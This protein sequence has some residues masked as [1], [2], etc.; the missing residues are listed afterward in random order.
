MSKRLIKSFIH[1][2]RPIFYKL[3]I[4]R[5]YYK[6]VGRN[7]IGIK[8]NKLLTNQSF[9]DK[10]TKILPTDDNISSISEIEKK[11]IIES[12][13]K[14]LSGNYNIL[15]SGDVIMNPIDWHSD[16]K[17]SFTWKKG[18]YYMD[19]IQVQLENDADVKVPRELSRSHHLLHVALA[20]NL[21]K[22]EEF[23]DFLRLQIINWIEENP[24]MYSINWGCAMDVSIRAVNW[25]WCL[26]LLSDYD[27][28]KHDKDLRFIKV[29][30][31]QHGWFIFRNLEGSI[32]NYTNNH[33]LSNLTGLIFLGQ[34]FNS[35]SDG[36]K[37]LNYGELSFYREIRIQILPSGIT[38]ERS[39]HYNRLVLELILWPL[40]SLKCS[41]NKIPQDIWSR[42][43]NMFEFIMHTSRPD[44]SCPIIGDQDNGRLLPFGTEEL[45]DFQY[46]L[47]IGSLLFKRAEFKNVD[48][49]YNIYSALLGSKYNLNMYEEID[50]FKGEIKSIGFNDVGLYVMRTNKNYLIFNGS[51]RGLYSD[52]KSLN[53][54]SH[55]DL[56]SF[57]L[58]IRDK[59]F[60]IDPGTYVYTSNKLERNLFR[61]TRKHNTVVVDGQNQ[62]KLS[63]N[64]LFQM[65]RDSTSTIKEWTT[66]NQQDLISA[67]HNGY[68]SLDEPVKHLRSITFEKLSENWLI[69]DQLLGDGI[70]DFEV[71]FHFNE[72]INI[73]IIDE[74]TIVT[75][76]KGSNLEL[77]F[78][79]N[80]DFKIVKEISYISKSYGTK[81]KSESVIIK[82]NSSCPFILET[83]IQII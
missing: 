54:H 6:F 56:F 12:A 48:Q 18:K 19:Y 76:S 38:Y 44:G 2:L 42:L 51:T 37:W 8:L 62:D 35:V 26:G 61:G 69:I 64:D 41:G 59:A 49:G 17:K 53:T 75:K 34:L 83:K 13:E 47:S 58:F 67:E 20:Y 14:V 4:I 10:I 72:H 3:P 36:K 33:Y 39:L 22:R 71:L 80:S 24:L 66:N 50:D 32:F 30:L 73:V 5:S 55:S 63:E 7:L 31:F 15:G 9:L 70:H 40:I 82:S 11:D 77:S 78:K 45:N 25:I 65:S 57:D 46:L 60:I 27:W 29:S 23:A 81:V 1:N 74:N 16:F 28:K 43:E 21:T 52:K 79:S 68:M